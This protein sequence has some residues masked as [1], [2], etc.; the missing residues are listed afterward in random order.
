M[1]R[2][3]NK[4]DQ[5]SDSA[6][7]ATPGEATGLR[8]ERLGALARIVLDRPRQRNAIN[9]AM[10]RALLATLTTWAKDPE[11][12]AVTIR[13]NVPDMFCAGGDV[14][15]LQAARTAD[16]SSALRDYAEELQLIWRV[17]CFPKPIVSLIDGP[18]MGTGAGLTLRGTHRVAARK[19]RFSMPETAIGFY[20]DVGVIH[21]LA[22]LQSGLG[23]L[24][25]LAGTPVDRATA[26]RAG[27]VTHCVDAE[28]FDEIEARLQAADTVDPL[29]D[30]LH[31]L[32][33]DEDTASLEERLAAAAIH[34]RQ[35]PAEILAGLSA[36]AE[37]DTRA[38]DLLTLLKA[39][40]P[41]SLAVTSGFLA[42][43]ASLD[44]R[45]TL[46]MDYRVGA[47]LLA[48]KDFTEGIRAAI[49]DK[50]GAPRWQPAT[51]AEVE[52]REI[53]QYFEPYP[54]GEL[55]LPT[56]AEMARLH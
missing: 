51:L 41:T 14:R 25:A 29:L 27:L 10:R 2:N 11:I 36:L 28:V 48:R 38:A 43:A 46:T 23:T 15:E 47:R 55:E 49:I 32:P 44:V 19:Y 26:L 17:E 9:R 7:N 18:V 20:P 33:S 54:T 56:L 50:D 16:L 40:C 35:R 6:G 3:V 52:D 22:R 5:P 42:L 45:E 21:A 8:L 4:D 31:R 37:H 34:G 12:Y 30:A 24:I 53:G 1:G 39:R 13:S